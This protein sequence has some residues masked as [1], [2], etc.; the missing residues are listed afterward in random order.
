MRVD[1]V[2]LNPLQLV[3]VIELHA[4]VKI[5]RQNSAGLADQFRLGLLENS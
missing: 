1:E 3:G 4:D 5:D 2:G